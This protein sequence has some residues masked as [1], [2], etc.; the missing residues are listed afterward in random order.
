MKH[1][2]F[3]FY[4]CFCSF[5]WEAKGLHQIICCILLSP[6]FALGV[7]SQWGSVGWC[8]GADWGSPALQAY[9]AYLLGMLRFEHQE[10]KA[11]IE[12]FNKCK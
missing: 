9:T 3:C 5:L 12:A 10:W 4:F 8:W 6:H 2:L 11:A 1:S 7:G